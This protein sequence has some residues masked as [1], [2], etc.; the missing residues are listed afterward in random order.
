[1]PRPDPTT[2]EHNGVGESIAD[3]LAWAGAS[4][5]DLPLER[6]REPIAPAEFDDDTPDT[7]R[8]EAPGRW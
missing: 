6:S 7:K 3:R 8:S 2:P 1:M 4:A 5:V